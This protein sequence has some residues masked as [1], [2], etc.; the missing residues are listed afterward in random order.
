MLVLKFIQNI[1]KLAWSDK[2][3]LLRSS[4]HILNMMRQKIADPFVFGY[5]LW[6]L[7]S[8]EILKK[9]IKINK[10]VH[11]VAPHQSHL[12]TMINCGEW[13]KVTQGVKYQHKN[14][15]HEKFLI[16]MH[17]RLSNGS[18]RCCKQNLL[19]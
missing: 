11:R 4:L 8:R 18:I 2:N 14:T 5:L 13:V 15:V 17:V 10:I 1:N 7:E 19:S 6:N 16:V 9:N 12:G 3:H